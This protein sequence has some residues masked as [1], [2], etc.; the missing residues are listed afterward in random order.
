MNKLCKVSIAL[1][2]LLLTN[3]IIGQNHEIDSLKNLL[4][5]TKNDTVR[6]N[7]MYELSEVLP[8]TESLEFSN[9]LRV[10]CKNEFKKNLSPKVNY[11]YKNI[12]ANS[13]LSINSNQLEKSNYHDTILEGFLETL[14]VYT[15]INNQEGV[16]EVYNAIGAYYYRKAL[17][18]EA[19]NYYHKALKLASKIGA[20]EGRASILNNL[21]AIYAAN[22]NYSAA[23]Q[24]Y[25]E[26]LTIK[27]YVSNEKHL[28]YLY[29]NLGRNFT[30]D[31]M[32][33][34]AQYYYEKS[35]LLAHE[36][37]F[38]R[39][40]IVVLNNLGSNFYSLKN[41]D[42]AMKYYKQSIEL[43]IANNDEYAMCHGYFRIAQLYYDT[44]R[45]E[46]AKDYAEN[47]L[48]LA[49]KQGRMELMK[50]ASSILMRIYEEK[51]DFKKAFEVSKIYYLSR[52]SVNNRANEKAVL[53]SQ[54]Q[55]QYDKKFLADSLKTSKDKEVLSLQI[56]KDRNQ[57]IFLY[58]I[59]IL[60]IIFTAFVFNRFRVAKKQKSVIEMA[61]KDLSRQHLLNQKIFSV[62]SHDFRG[63]M[64]SLTLMLESFKTKSTD[65]SLNIY[66]ESVASE[67]ANANEMLNNLLNWAR[68]EINI[69]EFEKSQCN[70]LEIF[71][72][73]A[74]EFKTKL[75]QK[76][77]HVKTEIEEDS[78]IDL[79]P[80]ILRIA[81][82]N[83]LSNAIKFSYNESSIE[84]KYLSAQTISVKDTGIGMSFEV[85]NKLSNREVDTGLGTN[86]E[87]GFGIG[88][89]IVSELLY[90]YGFKISV[91]S[92]EG[93]GS[94][95]FIQPL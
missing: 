1:F 45:K 89:Y 21:A 37:K 42:E 41:Y 28:S 51:G 86:N 75:D 92:Q 44:D 2:F 81:L 47:S 60:T 35:L 30:D 85:Q 19:I 32:Y 52:D 24:N 68:T 29:N 67:V 91:E 3:I 58:V 56:A 73:T 62:I 63:P 74:K 8:E 61:N 77:L 48:K 11:F 94:C 26:C 23:R 9:K 15:E 65:A 95:F 76:N 90:K 38:I 46:N 82:R 49:Q 17:F 70:V 10:I 72:E 14:N 57:K 16:C 69:V 13:L 71:N 80:D 7:L 87:E 36:G 5:K 54:Y 79:P 12:Y 27:E 50:N 64:L 93:V 25:Y 53:A 43:A 31:K 39:H 22:K 4:S 83:L 55:Y 34:S 88:L 84:I 40:E 59:I 18:N 66:V 6:C 33:D 20:N 78:K